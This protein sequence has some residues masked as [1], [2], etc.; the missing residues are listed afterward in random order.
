MLAFAAEPHATGR[1]QLTFTERSPLTTP[2]EMKRRGFM[3]G[4]SQEDQKK[5]Y[6]LANESFE[7]YVPPTYKSST[8]HGLIVWINPGQGDVE[9]AWFDVL[10]KH[11]L[12]WISPNHWF[13]GKPFQIHRGVAIDAVH[14]MKKL[15]NIDDKRIY[16]AGFSGGG[17]EAGFTLY[18]YP[19]VFRGVFFNNGETIYRSMYTD[20]TGRMQPGVW[21]ASWYQQMPYD[22]IKKETRIV[23]LTGEKDDWNPPELARADYESL[24]LDGFERASLFIVPRNGHQHPDAFWFEKCVNALDS[25]KSNKPPTTAPTT[26]VNL[27]PGQL[28]QAKRMLTTAQQALDADQKYENSR[29]FESA[30]ARKLLEQLVRDFP[31][32]PSAAT[33]R[34]LLEFARKSD[35]RERWSKATTKP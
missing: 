7:A 18:A 17:L 22:Q 2:V 26:Q 11:K 28:A 35:A 31:N 15:Y 10:S 20:D 29:K 33:A 1:L 27:Q 34:E 13:D 4:I 23:I 19:D 5:N 21:G 14:N 30:A 8:P 9:P 25:A 12:L 6:D 3:S 32:T 16:I 24:I